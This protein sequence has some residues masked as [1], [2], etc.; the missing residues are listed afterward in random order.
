MGICAL[1]ALFGDCFQDTAA[2]TPLPPSGRWSGADLPRN[3][4]QHPHCRIGIGYWWRIGQKTTRMAGPRWHAASANP[5]D[6][7]VAHQD[8]HND[9]ISH[10]ETPK[11]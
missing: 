7:R 10:M 1:Y 3:L 2:A 6:Q 11:T 4:W 8:C 9:R 5:T